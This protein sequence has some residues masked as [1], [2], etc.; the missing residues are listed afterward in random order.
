MKR[1]TSILYLSATFET[2]E[3]ALALYGLR[4][5]PTTLLTYGEILK[6]KL[7]RS[8]SLKFA[9]LQPNPTSRSLV[10]IR[11]FVSRIK[12]PLIP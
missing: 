6:F 4:F 8:H 1:M 3:L 12:Q 5:A 10:S 9:C 2:P 11:F 7:A